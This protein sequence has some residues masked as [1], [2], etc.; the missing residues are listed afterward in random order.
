VAGRQRLSPGISASEVG[1]E[2]APWSRRDTLTGALLTLV[3]LVGLSL[4]SNAAAPTSLA[5]TP[6]APNAIGTL[7]SVAILEGVF[8]IAP[9]YYA[10]RTGGH[11][12]W[13]SLGIR[14]I[15]PG[16]AIGLIVLAM[17]AT[18][19]ADL[20]Y[21]GITSALRLNV[22]T[23]AD[24]LEQQLLHLPLTLYATLFGAIFI[25][26]ICE[27][28]FFRGFLLQGLRAVMSAPWAVIVSSLIFAAAHAD[29][30]SFPLLLVLGLLMGTLRVLT[31][32]I[33]PG[34]ALHTFNNALTALL[35]VL[36]LHG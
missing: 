24:H 25:A 5:K 33:W 28:I 36:S 21:D 20:A 35:L 3:P 22:Q 10:H 32:S 26:P 2:A 8:L 11:K 4:I 30:G 13:Q 9:L 7:F 19:M 27:E 29:L 23:N 14:R 16:L 31:R 12:W 34:F 15:H 1:A 6:D 17:A 18:V